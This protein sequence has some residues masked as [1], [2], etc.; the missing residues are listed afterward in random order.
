MKR[1]AIRVDADELTYP[2]HVMLRFDLERR[3]LSGTIAVRDLREAWNEGMRQRLDLVPSSDAEGVLQDA[4]WASGSFGYFPLYAVGGAIAAQLAE[5]MR[6][7]L[8]QLD[9]QV[10]VG[11]FSAL[12]GWLRDS[13]HAEGARLSLQ[14]LLKNAT[15]KPLGATAALRYLERK[16][17]ETAA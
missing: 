14:E 9:E 10:A 5:Q 2:L 7:D 4:H 6:V 3:M 16:Y 1:S 12:R 15:G 11:D 8:P 17:L 13:I